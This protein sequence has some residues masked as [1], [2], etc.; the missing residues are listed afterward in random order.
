MK[1]CRVLCFRVEDVSPGLI[2]AHQMLL[3]DNASKCLT[4][5]NGVSEILVKTEQES[6]KIEAPDVSI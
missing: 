2:A 6:K 3:K 4:C 1:D 5:D